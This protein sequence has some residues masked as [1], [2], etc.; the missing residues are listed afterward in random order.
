MMSPHVL[1]YCFVPILVF[2]S[3]FATDTHIFGRQK[4]QIF[5]LAGPGVLLSSVLTGGFSKWF[6]AD[7]DWSW[8]ACLMSNG[9]AGDAF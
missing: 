8:P 6:F 7:Y 2:E 9:R 1:L 5:S 4:W 3:A